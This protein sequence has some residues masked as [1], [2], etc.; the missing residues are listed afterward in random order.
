MKVMLKAGAEIDLLNRDELQDSLRRESQVAELSRLYGIKWMRLPENL[1]G[2]AAGGVLTLGETAGDVVGPESGYAWVIKRLIVTGLTGGA[3]PDVVNL[4]RGTAAGTPLW[5]FNGGNF[6]YT[7]GKMELTLMGGEHLA[8]ASVGTFT[9]TSVI[10]LAGELI[11]VP[12]QLLGKL[13]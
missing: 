13:A 2:T 9:S 12:A 7:F 10:T 4:Y 6:G 5:Q 11:E 1:S 8:L 3:A